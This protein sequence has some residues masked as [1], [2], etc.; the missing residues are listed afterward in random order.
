MSE[1]KLAQHSPEIIWGWGV[2]ET[3]R[4]PDYLNSTVK[5]KRSID[6]LGILELE[7]SAA[8]RVWVLLRKAFLPKQVLSRVME[9]IR[10]K[11][12][13]F[14]PE[15]MDRTRGRFDKE[16][17]KNEHWFAATRVASA[18]VSHADPDRENV[19]DHYAAE[20]DRQLTIIREELEI[21]L[22]DQ[23]GEQSE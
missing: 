22:S 10:E 3:Y 23:G 21:W 12:D 1:K 9:R 13:E 18:V 2:C 19:A 14:D 17:R 16:M 6:A 15:R 11:C 7:I 5:G 8:D 20:Y 4:N